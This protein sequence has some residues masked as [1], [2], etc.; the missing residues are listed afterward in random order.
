MST[1]SGSPVSLSGV[2]SPGLSSMRPRAVHS[3]RAGQERRWT[4]PS[5]DPARARRRRASRA[6]T[7]KELAATAVLAV[8]LHEALAALSQ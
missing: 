7:R 1:L 6:N 2:Y 3:R 8:P 5:G 4:A